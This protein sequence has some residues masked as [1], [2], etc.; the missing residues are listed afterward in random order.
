MFP[1]YKEDK[2]LTLKLKVPESNDD[3]MLSQL[4]SSYYSESAEQMVLRCGICCTHTTACPQIGPC[5]SRNAVTQVMLTKSPKYLIVQLMR[6]E[7]AHNGKIL[8]NVT[9]GNILQLPHQENYELISVTSHMGINASSGHYVTFVN[10]LGLSWTL[11]NDTQCSAVPE[12]DVFSP[13]NYIYVFKKSSNMQP[14]TNCL[15]RNFQETNV[16]P[17]NP[18]FLPK[19]SKQEEDLKEKADD[20][21][22]VNIMNLNKSS[23]TKQ[24]KHP[25]KANQAQSFKTHEHRRKCH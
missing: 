24:K 4:I 21:S 1:A 3:I 11:C 17:R 13:D 15:K 8:T 2:F 18:F 12:T 9:P 25:R 7:G 22:D 10:L 19:K 20:R 16:H 14:H 5:K 23:C 6:F